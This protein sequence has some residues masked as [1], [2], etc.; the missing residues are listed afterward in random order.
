MRPRL[1]LSLPFLNDLPFFA[2]KPS[3]ENG[4]IPGILRRLASM[5]YESFLLL[6]VV[7]LAGFVFVSLTQGATS[8]PVK[9]VF[10]LYITGVVAA[11]FLWFWLHGGQTLAMKTWHLRLVGMDGQPVSLRQALLRFVVAVPGVLSGLSVLWALFD[12]DRQFLHDRLAKTKIIRS[13]VSLQQNR[14]EAAQNH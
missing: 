5:L 1:N 8:A 10:Q 14:G 2:L 3:P 12:R 6:A 4:A 7:F 9:L 13:A 11:Y